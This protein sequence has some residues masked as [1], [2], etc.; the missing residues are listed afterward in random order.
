MDHH[1]AIRAYDREIVERRLLRLIPV[2]ELLGVVHNQA[3][4]AQA[5]GQG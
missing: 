4:A 2:F 3:T 1:V 5:T